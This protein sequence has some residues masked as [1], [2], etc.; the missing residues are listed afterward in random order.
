MTDIDSDHLPLLNLISD[1]YDRAGK[2][3]RADYLALRSYPEDIGFF[4]T[5]ENGHE[6]HHLT[7]EIIVTIQRFTPNHQSNLVFLGDRSVCLNLEDTSIENYYC[8]Y[9]ELRY[10]LDGSLKVE[11]ESNPVIFKDG[12][13][14]FMNSQAYHHEVLQDSECTVIN[15][16]MS[17]RIFNDLFLNQIEIPKLQQFLRAHLVKRGIEERFLCFTPVNDDSR[18]L[19][20]D[21]FRS[22]LEEAVQ[23]RAGRMYFYQGYILQLMDHLSSRYNVMRDSRDVQMYH[24]LLM[25]SVSNFM[26]D[27]LQ[28]V[29]LNDLR[30]AYHYHPNFFTSLIRKYHGVTFSEYLLYLRVNRAKELLKDTSMNVDEIIYLVG[31]NNKT[32]FTRKFTEQTGL[33]PAKFRRNSRP[34][35]H[36]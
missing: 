8:D 36:Q 18:N 35:A 3:I 32:F 10:I 9:V 14:C 1:L 2:E 15:V 5:F 11:I 26:K 33:S 17:V 4:S 19:I 6:F 22:I 30:D 29:T 34:S 23:N 27:H 24:D 20:D 13:V 28:D 31:Y 16:N 21:S 12:E 25:E 7:H